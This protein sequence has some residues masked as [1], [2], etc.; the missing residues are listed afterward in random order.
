VADVIQRNTIQD[1]EVFVRPTTPHIQSRRPSEPLC[2][3][4]SS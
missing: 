2:T 4:G 1:D 3:P